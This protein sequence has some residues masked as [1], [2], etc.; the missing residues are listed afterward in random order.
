V[1]SL[2]DDSL[3]NTSLTGDGLHTVKILAGRSPSQASTYVFLISGSKLQLIKLILIYFI[4]ITVYW[5]MIG[6]VSCING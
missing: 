5:F 2:T 1:T 6:G 4:A 3:P